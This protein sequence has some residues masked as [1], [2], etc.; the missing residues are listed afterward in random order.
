[1]KKYIVLFTILVI[2][3]ATHLY[4]VFSK[5]DGVEVYDIAVSTQGFY[6][7]YKYHKS[8]KGIIKNQ[9]SN[10]LIT[11]IN[12]NCGGGAGCY[13]HGKTLLLLLIKVGDTKFSNMILSFNSKE[14]STLLSLLSAG[15]EYGGLYEKP[16]FK[17]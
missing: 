4:Q 9:E 1:M 15:H 11:L 12:S 3:I 5:A 10:S 2:I 16:N 14:K 8:I 6:E 13:E 7:Q 17:K